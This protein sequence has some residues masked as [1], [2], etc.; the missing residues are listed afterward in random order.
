MRASLALAKRGLGQTWPNPSVGCVIV[1]RN[2]VV[3]G[4]GRTQA[5]GRPHAET[6]ALS[7]AGPG[8][9]GATAYVTLE[10]CAHTG[11][12]GPCA[13]AL[14]ASGITRVVSAI[15]DP[16]PRVAGRGHAMLRAAGVQVDIGEGAQEARALNAGFFKRLTTGRPFVT[17]KLATSL[18]GRMALANG[19]SQWI[20]GPESRAAGHLLRSRQDAILTGIGTVL[21]DD[22][23]LDCRLP[24]LTD[25]SP[26]PV[27]L[28]THGRLPASAALLTVSRPNP[29]IWCCGPGANPAMR[30]GTVQQTIPLDSHGRLHLASALTELGTQGLTQILVEAGPTVTTAFLAGGHVDEIIWFRAPIL[31]GGDSRAAVSALNLSSLVDAQRFSRVAVSQW[32]VDLMETYRLGA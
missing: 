11:Q 13:Q 17:L 32:G 22:P 24:G 12:T 18:D 19:E 2:G 26:V 21:S 14:L 5:G 7:Q 10:P 20:T 27:V 4:R 8:A 16:D 31:L 6:T 15:E 23:R 28:D 25:R 9:R 1:G 30:A 3:V 29:L